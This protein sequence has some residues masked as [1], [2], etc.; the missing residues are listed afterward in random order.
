MFF[1]E[2]VRYNPKPSKQ[3]K[4]RVIT[5]HP[6]PES[7]QDQ[8]SS[9]APEAGKPK[10]SPAKVKAK[11]P[12]TKRAK[13]T[14]SAAKAPVV[15]KQTKPAAKAAKAPVAA[16]KKAVAT[17]PAAVKKVAAKKIVDKKVAAAAP[18]KS[19]KRVGNK[20]V[21]ID[22]KITVN[23]G[24]RALEFTLDEAE[25]LAD[26]LNLLFKRVQIGTPRKTK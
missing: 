21:T 14:L 2:S 26:K 18:S 5:E 3:Q 13:V 6:A 12:V 22:A 20:G 17:K 4:G 7:S 19:A 24:A 9:A 11:A 1:S 8:Q 10:K 15:A 25:E 23:V 16:K